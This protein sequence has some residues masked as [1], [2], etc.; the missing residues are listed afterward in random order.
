MSKSHYIIIP[1]DILKDI[2]AGKY[3][4]HFLVANRKSTDEPNNQKNSIKYQKAENMRYAQKHNLPI[5]PI[6]IDGF[7][8]DG[9]ISERHSAF[10][11]DNELQFVGE[12]QV[13]FRIERPKFYLLTQLLSKGYFKGVIHL[14]WDRASRNK[15]DDTIIRK[16]IKTGVNMHFTLAKYDDTSSGE[17]QMDVEGMFAAHHSRVTSEKVTIAT[18]DNRNR[19]IVTHKAGVGYLNQGTMD[20]K[21]HDPLRAPLILRFAELADEG[22][23]L[24]SICRFAIEQGFTMPP[25]RRRRTNEEILAEEEDDIRLEVEAVSRLPTPNSIHKILTNRFYTGKVSTHDGQWV[26][27][28]S[29]EA[30][31]P[32][33]LFNRVQEKLQQKNKSVHYANVLDHPCRGLFHCGTCGRVYTPYPQKGILYFGARC[34]KDCTNTKKSFNFDFITSEVGKLI[35]ALSFTPDELEEIDARTST[36]IALV[37]TKRLNVIETNDRKKKAIRESLA[38]LNAHRL[39]LLKAGAYTPEQIVAEEARLRSELSALQETESISDEAMRET[40]NDVIK[41]SE[42]LKEGAVYYSL[43]NPKEKEAIIRIIFSELLIVGNTLQYKCKNGF[44]AFENR[45]VSLGDPTGN[46]TRL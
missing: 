19:G 6:T 40:V 26:A 37:E 18:R 4:D 23:S 44:K 35:N 25:V 11:E 31:I 1:H 24:S 8:R 28:K 42:L 13:Q 10:K 17:L 36:Q 43:A 12:N 16:L 41:L 34:G 39:D 45:F 2:E 33:E 22:W 21:P 5:A 29:H 46:R 9:V 14:C 32:E 27:S 7:C 38:Y 3:R 20:H 30:I 15:T